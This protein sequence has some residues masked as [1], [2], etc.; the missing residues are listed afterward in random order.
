MTSPPDFADQNC[1]HENEDRSCQPTTTENGD[2]GEQ[3]TFSLSR[4]TIVQLPVL[5][6]G[7]FWLNSGA[8][9]ILARELFWMTSSHSGI[10]Q[11]S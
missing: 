10:L 6:C 1:Y 9:T 8:R 4:P 5:A 11:K 7:L 3:Q 2:N